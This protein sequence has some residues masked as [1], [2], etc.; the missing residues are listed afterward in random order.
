MD[1]YDQLSAGITGLIS[2][3]T[4]ERGGLA[5]LAGAS[6]SLPVAP[7]TAYRCYELLHNTR[8]PSGNP[9]AAAIRQA[10]IDRVRVFP[11]KTRYVVW[12]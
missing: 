10:Q 1:Y 3:S 4:L 8:Q 12:I 5:G 7:A 6:R 2:L 9:I 11:D